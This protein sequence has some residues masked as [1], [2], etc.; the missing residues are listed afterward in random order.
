MCADATVDIRSAT[1]T[2]LSSN[3][4]CARAA[5]ECA[6]VVSAEALCWHG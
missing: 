4:S 2:Q 1:G 5:L 3:A 6:D